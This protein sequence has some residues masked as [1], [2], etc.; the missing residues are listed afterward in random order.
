MHLHCFCIVNSSINAAG[1]HLAGGSFMEKAKD[2]SQNYV[3]SFCG[4]VVRCS[5]VEPMVL[6]STP[7]K[8]F[9]S[10]FLFFFRFLCYCFL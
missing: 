6:G 7:T 4:V 5:R 3:I 2:F 9:F 1:D 10:F 8:F